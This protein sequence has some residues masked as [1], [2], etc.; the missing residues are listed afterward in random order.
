M[1]RHTECLCEHSTETFYALI[2][3]IVA[4]GFDEATAAHYA[5]LI[6]DTPIL[7]EEGKVVVLDRAGKELARLALN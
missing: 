5:A 6:G 4:L 1:K 3:S 7:D 2:D